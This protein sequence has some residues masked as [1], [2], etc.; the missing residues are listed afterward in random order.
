MRAVLK[1]MTIIVLALVPIAAAQAQQQGSN[2]APGYA[3]SRA[4]AGGGYGSAYAAP[5]A[6]WTGSYAYEPYAP[7][8]LRHRR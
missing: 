6:P 1:A 4:Q 8:R 3:T 5:P 7:R 2:Q